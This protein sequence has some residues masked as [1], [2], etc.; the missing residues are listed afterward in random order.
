MWPPRPSVIIHP[1]NCLLFSVFFFPARQAET[2][3]HTHVSPSCEL[4][5]SETTTTG[6]KKRKENTA[7][8]TPRLFGVMKEQ[9]H[10]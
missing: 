6:K 8:Q 9:K 10:C 4:I 3:F 2:Q 7:V 5:G 1:L